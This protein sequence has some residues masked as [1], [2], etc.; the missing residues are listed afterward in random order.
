MNKQL[1]KD[2]PST[3]ARGHYFYYDDDAGPQLME[4]DGIPPGLDKFN[5]S[6]LGPLT[7]IL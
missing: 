7:L 2:F 5:N 6:H 3:D 1:L 4:S